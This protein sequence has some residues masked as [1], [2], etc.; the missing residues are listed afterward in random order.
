[1]KKAILLL[2]ACFILVIACKNPINPPGGGITVTF[3]LD[4]GSADIVKTPNNEGIVT[5]PA[6]PSKGDMIFSGWYTEL[7]GGHL[8]DFETVIHANITLYAHYVSSTTVFALPLA[9]VEDIIPYLMEQIAQGAAEPI[10]L[11]LAL[12]LTDPKQWELLYSSLY[13][14]DVFVTLDLSSCSDDS[15]FSPPK[16]S[17]ATGGGKVVELILPADTT[18]LTRKSMGGD[19]PLNVFPNLI[20]VTGHNVTIIGDYAFNHQSN[21][22]TMVFKKTEEIWTHSFNDTGSPITIYLGSTAP[23]FDFLSGEGTD[24]VGNITVIVPAGAIGYN[25]EWKETFGGTVTV[26]YQ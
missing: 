13:T 26:V 20:K 8:F 12:G 24:F 15:D 1:M 2:G 6:N 17:G 14:A 21:I 16:G 3:K 9:D 11:P 18:S 10:N 25:D 5:P 19:S 22:E 23:I 4:N 7:V